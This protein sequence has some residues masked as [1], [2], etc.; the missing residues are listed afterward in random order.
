MN[1]MA[2]FAEESELRG[3]T[4][5]NSEALAALPHDLSTVVQSTR[6]EQSAVVSQSS[7]RGEAQCI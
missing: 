3:S 6:P 7:C 5:E 4:A 1:A 2:A